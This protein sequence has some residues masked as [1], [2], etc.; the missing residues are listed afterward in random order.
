MVFSV[1][2][3][4]AEAQWNLKQNVQNLFFFLKKKRLIINAHEAESIVFGRM[5][6]KNQ[7]GQRQLRIKYKGIQ[8]SSIKWS[9]VYLARN[10][11]S[12]MK[13]KNFLRKTSNGIK[14]L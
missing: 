3:N 11:T 12:Q 4:V 1:S 2:R 14:E 8:T 13:V 6:C 10:L 5:S 7:W 9:G